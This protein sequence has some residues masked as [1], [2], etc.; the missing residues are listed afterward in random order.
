M[1]SYD[2]TGVKLSERQSSRRAALYNKDPSMAWAQDRAGIRRDLGVRGG[3]GASGGSSR[4]DR[5]RADIAETQSKAAKQRY[6]ES[7]G[8]TAR[9]QN[10][11]Q[12]AT[13]SSMIDLNEKEAQAQEKSRLRQFAGFA[14][15]L[16]AITP[17][18]DGRVKLPKDMA[19]MLPGFIPGYSGI[20]KG[21]RSP[22]VFIQPGKSPGGQPTMDFMQK[23]TDGAFMPLMNNGHPVSPQVSVMSEAAKIGRFEMDLGADKPKDH[24]NNTPAQVK[25]VE[26]VSR[27]L[28]DGDM[29]QAWQMA[30]Q[31]K[32]NPQEL[33]A[34][35]FLAE[36]KNLA[37]QYKWNPDEMPGDDEIMKSVQ[38]AMQAF[39]NGA[40]AAP[41][42]RPPSAP[43][44]P[45]APGA[46]GKN[47]AILGQAG[48]AIKRGAS[49]DAVVQRLIKMGVSEAE[50]KKAGL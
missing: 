20:S 32:Q 26:W 6:L 28:T 43:P 44:A 13:R 48:D 45:T 15:R 47:R 19:G 5:A 2:K 30:Q 16:Q 27:N 3:N 21:K 14:A 46:A 10:P 12:I 18:K 1:A 49:R 40:Q 33:A 22:E 4:T 7:L 39:G 11:N 35:L 41:G 42:V 29:D 34:K 17:D 31:S 50:I 36:K 24:K 23:D 38:S 8:Q 37:G 25:L 9:G